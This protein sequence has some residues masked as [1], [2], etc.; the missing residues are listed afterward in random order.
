MS[1]TYK[2][3]PSIGI[4]R[5]GNTTLDPTKSIS[6]QGEA[7]YIA[8]VQ[9]GGLPLD[10]KTFQ[11]IQTSSGL[12]PATPFRNTNGELK[13]QAA[14]FQ[15]IAY[16]GDEDQGTQVAV[17]SNSVKSIKW[18]VYL[19]NKKASWYQFTQ[20]TGSGQE[21]DKGYKAEN[22]PLRN[23]EIT[24]SDRNGLILDPGPRTLDGPSQNASFNLATKKE[25]TPNSIDNLGSMYTDSA[26]NLYVFGGQGNS[27][28]TNVNPSDYPNYLYATTAYANNK[29]WYDDVADGPVTATIIME[30]GSEIEVEGAWCIAGPPGYA[31]QIV[32][33]V[34]LY[35]TM[36]DVFVRSSAFPNFETDLYN[37]ATGEF[38][39]DYKASLSYIQELLNRPNVY[40]Y[41]TNMP[42]LA[43]NNHSL[44]ESES[45]GT[46]PPDQFPTYILRSPAQKDQAGL[47]P[48]LAGDNPISENTIS[49]YLTLTATQYFL[50]NQW[51][52]G[53]ST[54]DGPVMTPGQARDM[55]SLAN[56]VG[57]PF[58]PGIEMTW[59]S[60]NVT[61]YN[62]PFRIRAI[63][64]IPTE[65]GHLNWDN[66][67][68][69]D[70]T[71]SGVEPGDLS[72]Y[73]AQPWQ[74]DFN[75]CSIQ[76][77]NPD[78]T[79]NNTEGLNPPILWWW[80]AQRPLYVTPE[81][82]DGEVVEWTRG[83]FQ[84]PDSVGDGTP[85]IGDMQM[86]TNWKD[87]GFVVLDASFG[88]Y[89]EIQRNT[90]AIEQYTKDNPP[91][92]TI[93]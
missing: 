88:G 83:Y 8:P 46:L 47:M 59:I 39:P 36:Y 50:I 38:N 28:T 22:V 15:I 20:L 54:K 80:P 7:F 55:A 90:A 85:N 2:I 71:T 14:F 16:Q 53:K 68:S 27:G 79:T 41:V 77:I 21:G 82:S 75:E 10:P 34:N 44:V 49:K 84:D 43:V 89:Q 52:Q 33:Q 62:A 73:M 1:T 66:G 58:C 91:L 26:S 24:G 86:V 11:P 9:A 45:K 19:A 17:G 42:A 30:D 6:D 56:C 40:R 3:H 31:P 32:N 92:K 35:D 63:S 93:T 74:T 4:A 37:K 72:K 51:V 23:S 70:Y 5:V 67:V 76:P 57:G 64:N 25:L 12:G 61:I 29:G 87:L 60:R 18:T 81:G 65:P 48:K 69:G 78:A 13:K